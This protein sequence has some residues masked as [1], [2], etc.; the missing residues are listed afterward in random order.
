LEAIP[1]Y[2]DAVQRFRDFLRDEGHPDS[3]VWLFRE[4]F[5]ATGFPRHRVRFPPPDANRPL[6]EAYFEKARERGRGV[7]L[8]AHFRVEGHSAA[9]IW[10]SDDF[11][12][13]DHTLLSGLKLSAATPFP[14]ARPVRSGLLWRLHRLSSGYRYQQRA[15]FD[16][17]TRA[18]VAAREEEA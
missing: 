8:R 5:Y 7:S 16:V 6:A 2:S 13:A 3:V 18:E 14:N 17:P 9:S 11:L 1:P 4:D 10:C 15:G 12:D